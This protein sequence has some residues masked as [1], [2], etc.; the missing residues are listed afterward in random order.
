MNDII[1]ISTFPKKRRVKRCKTVKESMNFKIED[2]S[3]IKIIDTNKYK[4][5]TGK[6]S[7]LKN[8]DLKRQLEKCNNNIQRNISLNSKNDEA[9]SSTTNFTYHEKNIKKVTF[10]TVEIIRVEMFKN[11]NEKS[12]FSKESI[13]QNIKD[14][15]SEK[16]DM[17]LCS[18]F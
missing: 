10:S 13:Q 2:E 4:F 12:N 17:S 1:S 5:I 3:P 9:Y 8:N 16:N 7:F 14:L 11:Y 6:N 15:K 18:I